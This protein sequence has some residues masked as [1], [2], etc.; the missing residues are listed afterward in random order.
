MPETYLQYTFDQ[1]VKVSSK[2]WIRES[3]R[4]DCL[5]ILWGRYVELACPKEKEAGKNA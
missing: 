3:D 5:E 1:I 4:L 2:D